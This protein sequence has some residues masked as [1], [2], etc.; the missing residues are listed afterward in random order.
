MNP[1]RLFT[2]SQAIA[3][4]AV[5]ASLSLLASCGG[6]DDGSKTTATGQSGTQV[7]PTPNEDS[8]ASSLLLTVDDFPVGW[9]DTP[10]SNQPNP[11]DKCEQS[12]KG[13][14]GKAES[15]DFSKGGSA[16]VGQ[17]V[18]V[19]DTSEDV[20]ASFDQI[21]TS[22]DCVV[23]AFNHG[24]L[25]TDKASYS[26]ASFSPLSFTSYGDRSDAFR[27]KV[28]AN[29]NGQTGL[30]SEADVY[31]DFINVVDGRIGF[32]LVA[33]DVYSPFDT[34]QLQ[35]IVSKAQAKTASR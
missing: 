24:E 15:G 7:T 26:D 31:I 1:S 3:L 21:Q 11:L 8:L 27:F 9:A 14:T 4:A 17:T 10:R 34:T 6:G 35:Q 32:S 29:V 28:H 25:D 20:S 12:G 18:V 13:R 19:Y 22:A 2:V 23:Q 5:L 33:S 30:G 16:S